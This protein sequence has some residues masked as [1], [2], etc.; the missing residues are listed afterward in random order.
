MSTL[1]KNSLVDFFIL[2]FNSLFQFSISILYGSIFACRS[3]C[4]DEHSFLRADLDEKCWQGR[5]S[6]YALGLGLPMLFLYVIGLPV[7]AFLRLRKLR[8]H[9]ITLPM[10]RIYGLLYSAFRDNT[11][12][13]EGTVAARKIIIALIGVFGASMGSMQ[14]HLTLM[15]VMLIILMTARVRPFGGLKHGLNHELEIASLM[16]TFLTLWAGSVFNT[17]PKCQDP[18]KADGVTLPWCDAL[19]IF[20]GSVDVIV[21]IAVVVVFCYLKVESTKED[22]DDVGVDKHIRTSSW[23]DALPVEEPDRHDTVIEMVPQKNA[24][25]EMFKTVAVGS[26]G[27][28]SESKEAAPSS[29]QDI[30]VSVSSKS[31]EPIQI[32]I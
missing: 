18:S 15:L 11:W 24:G 22:D 21:V 27:S 14:V 9:A 17:Y 3:I 2:F 4:D 23:G 8:E 5:H 16:A 20:A 29:L 26:S 12:W 31:G 1:E 25:V 32:T 7:A 30:T 13:W 6:A 28:G 10:Q 19:S